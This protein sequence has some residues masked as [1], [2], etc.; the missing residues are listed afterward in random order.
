[1]G[2]DKVVIVDLQV[3]IEEDVN[4]YRAVSVFAMDRL[5]GSAQVA[6]YQL[7]H[8]QHLARRERGG[9]KDA[10]IEKL[11]RTLKAPWGCFDERGH[12]LHLAH[13]LAQQG[14]GRQKKLPAVAQIGA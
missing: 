2:N 4:V 6:F 8:L 3:I 5:F 10:R 7:G 14:Y 11:M 9:N 12:A 13:S 1:M